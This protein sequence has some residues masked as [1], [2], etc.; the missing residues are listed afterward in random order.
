MSETKLLI[1]KHFPQLC[2]CYSDLHIRHSG[3]ESNLLFYIPLSR[4]YTASGEVKRRALLYDM[5]FGTF[6]K[7]A[8]KVHIGNYH[9]NVKT[10]IIASRQPEWFQINK[11]CKIRQKNDIIHHLLFHKSD[12]N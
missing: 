1:N 12:P 9:I 7:Y 6:T 5:I 2:M 8:K 4:P 3:T 11:S 10:G